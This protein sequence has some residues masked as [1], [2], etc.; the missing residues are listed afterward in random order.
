MPNAMSLPVN[1]RLYLALTRTPTHVGAGQGLDDIDLPVYR[2]TWGLPILPGSSFKGVL[3]QAAA[4]ADGS[5]ADTVQTLY[6]PDPKNAAKHAGMLALQ[7]ARLLLLPVASLRGGWAWVTSAGLLWR[8]RRDAAAAGLAG[9]PQPPP[10]LEPGAHRALVG[11]SGSPLAMQVHGSTQAMLLEAA[12]TLSVSSTVA[13]W[14]A[15]LAAL[16]FPDDDAAWR[17]A[18]ESRMVLVDDDT[19]MDFCRSGTE[20]RARV[21]LDENRVAV[22]GA[23]WREECVPADSLFWGV[24]SAQLVPAAPAQLEPAEAL[25]RV[26]PA[27]LQLG[28]KA[29]VGYGWVDFLPQPGPQGQSA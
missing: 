4:D 24:F 16:A 20:V 5:D 25:R 9:L 23:L 14:A 15:H 19:F 18:F 29:S 10:A 17:S 11:Q 22:D 2:N 26:R 13:A 6:G 27:S 21:R 12:L 1:H 7:D 8:Y 28:G 3:R